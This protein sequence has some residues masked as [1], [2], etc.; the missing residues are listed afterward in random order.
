MLLVVDV[1]MRGLF[2]RG[3]NLSLF[4][5]ASKLS[6]WLSLYEIALLFFGLI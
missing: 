5:K 4:E 1:K 6:K 3:S 2:K